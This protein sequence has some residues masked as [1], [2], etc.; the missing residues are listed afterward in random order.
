MKKLLLVATIGIAGLA[1]AKSTLKKVENI[2]LTKTELKKDIKKSNVNSFYLADI[3]RV[4]TICG[5]TYVTIMGSSEV[6]YSE[7]EGM[8][9][10][11]CGHSSYEYFT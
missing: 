1:S 2:E 7:W 10:S 8:N 9:R 5:A 6:M 3:V 11:L 4:R